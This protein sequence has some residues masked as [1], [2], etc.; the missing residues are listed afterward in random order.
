MVG[1]VECSSWTYVIFEC[2][3]QSNAMT[4]QKLQN[5]CFKN[6]LRVPKRTSTQ[7]IHDALDMELLSHPR[8][9]HVAIEM[10]KVANN[11]QPESIQNMFQLKADVQSKATKGSAS[12]KFDKWRP[13]LEM[14]KISFRYRG[15]EVWDSVP[16]AIQN[17]DSLDTF[18]NLLNWF[19]DNFKFSTQRHLL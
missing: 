17:S 16:L 8:W 19:S 12:N 2:L 4:L 10:F 13:R 15:V 1:A 6:I 14:T 5:M 3:N 11:L 9:R 7:E 18:K